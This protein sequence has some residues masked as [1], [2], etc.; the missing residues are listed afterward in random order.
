MSVRDSL[1][2]FLSESLQLLFKL[3]KSTLYCASLCCSCEHNF[4]RAKQKSSFHIRNSP[5]YNSWKAIIL[6][7]FFFIGNF[8]DINGPTNFSI[9]NNV[10]DFPAIFFSLN[11]KSFRNVSGRLLCNFM[12]I[13]LGFRSND[14]HF[15]GF[16][17]QDGAFWL[18][19]SQYNSRESF[20]V[21]PWVLDFFRNKL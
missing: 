15:A 5:V 1:S 8:A 16:K 7:S 4:S 18:G 21:I 19:L 12:S 6:G 20:F 9:C 3:G 17:D 13:F 11:I 14:D 10:C 2:C